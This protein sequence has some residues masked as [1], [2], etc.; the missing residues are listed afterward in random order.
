MKKV[1]KFVFDTW[2]GA[3]A[4]WCVTGLS[5]LVFIYF[6]GSNQQQGLICCGRS[7]LGLHVVWGVIVLA[8]VT[9]S[10]FRKRWGLAIGQF[11]L[12]ILHAGAFCVAVL[13]TVVAHHLSIWRS[14]EPTETLPFSVQ[15]RAAHPF[16]AE[17]DKRIEFKSG[18]RFDLMMDTGGYADFKCYRLTDGQFYLTDVQ[19]EYRVN[20]LAE[21]VEFLR[22]D[23]WV[24]VSCAD[25]GVPVGESLEGKRFLGR[26]SPQGVFTSGGEEPVLPAETRWQNL[27]AD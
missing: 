24:Q 12:A 3:L 15:Y 20:P 2:Y 14:T 6:W 11:V 16:L 21:T 7:L 27:N 25:E 5:V 23:L 18:R 13:V 8:A 4:V 1:L 10:A 9:R 19:C 17:Y 26:I 22:D